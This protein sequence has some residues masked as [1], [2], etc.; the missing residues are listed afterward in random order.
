MSASGSQSY[1]AMVKQA[2]AT[3]RTIPS[4]PTL[5]KVNFVSDSLGTTIS[6]KV[7]N[8]IR[9]D[10][11][12]TDLTTT[13]LSVGGGYE[14]EF[15]YENSLLDELLL[16]FIWAEEWEAG[17]SLTKIAKNGSF[18]QPFFIER[19]HTDVNQYFKFLGMAANT[20]EL[21]FADQAD[22]TGNYQFVGLAS[23]VDSEIETGATYTEQTDN[24]VFSCVTNVSE[25][26]IG[27]VVQEDCILKEW[28]LSINN[29]VTPKTGVGILGACETKVHR[30]SIT[31]N[32]PMYFSDPAMF[33][34]LKAGTPFALSWKMED[35]EGNAYKF[36]LPRVKL[37]TDEIFVEG[38]EEDVM[39]NATYV[40]T[41][42]SVLGCM[43]QIE[44]S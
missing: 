23:Q 13:G 12:T 4:T 34:R 42:D 5:Q 19:G 44:K 9:A 15:Q 38:S 31:G 27:G 25:I 14:F 28:T 11:A 26:S 24:P 29:N 37:A 3:P 18:Y 10:R 16:A 20:M 43:I 35:G 33:N 8:H 1:I 6:T 7:S 22:V 30:L 36:T 39:D 17:G 32:L 41:H 2:P 40:A 21:S